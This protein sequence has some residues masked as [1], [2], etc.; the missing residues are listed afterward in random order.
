MSAEQKRLYRQAA[1]G[2]QDL[3]LYYT[4]KILNV[5]AVETF[6]SQNNDVAVEEE[7]NQ[8]RDF[9]FGEIQ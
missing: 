2:L 3:Y 1:S 5:D 4:G 8:L 6:I 7:I 9:V